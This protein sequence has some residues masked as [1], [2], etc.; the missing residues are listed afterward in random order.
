M[1]PADLLHA[2]PNSLRP[3]IDV[4]CMTDP[5]VWGILLAVAV[6]GVVAAVLDVLVAERALGARDHAAEKA[7]ER[8][9]STSLTAREVEP[10]RAWARSAG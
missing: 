9:G 4:A 2:V 10:E 6:F 5:R 3:P 1:N 7:L 8:L